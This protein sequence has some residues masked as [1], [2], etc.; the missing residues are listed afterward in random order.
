MSEFAGPTMV[1]INEMPDEMDAVETTEW[2][3]AIDSSSSMGSAV[4]SAATGCR[5]I[6]IRG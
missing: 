4:R 6:H 5:P 2:L 1:V 3:E